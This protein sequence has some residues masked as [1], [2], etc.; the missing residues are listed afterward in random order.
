VREFARLTPYA[1]L[2]RLLSLLSESDGTLRRSD[3]PA[4]A[5]EV[6]LLKVAELPRLV[7]IE[8]IL[9]GR[10]PVPPGAP[11]ASSGGGAEGDAGRGFSSKVNGGPVRTEAGSR[12][13]SV[14]AAETHTL[15]KK[16]TDIAGAPPKHAAGSRAGMPSETENSSSSDVPR[17]VGL[18]PLEIVPDRVL[19][20]DPA[21][22]FR[23]AVEKKHSQLGAVLDDASIR[24]EGKDVLIALDPPSIVTEKRLAEPAMA[25]VLEEAAIAVLGKGA[26]VT[27]EGVD[28]PAGDLTAAAAVADPKALEREHLKMKVATDERVKRMMDLFGG[29]IA[30]VKRDGGPD[31]AKGR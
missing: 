11:G 10:I 3:V 24:L 30:D 21:G 29:E 5:F 9:A 18:T 17:F 15:S 12:A 4:L 25:K 22:A 1:T 14:P 6:L 13:R 27:V 23:A 16:T 8:D 31:R 7:P 20:P 26:K 28:P 19:T 2:L